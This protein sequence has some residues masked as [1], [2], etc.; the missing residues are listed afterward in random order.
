MRRSLPAIAGIFLLCISLASLGLS[1]WV[2][3]GGNWSKG[4]G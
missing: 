4:K 2:A 1:I 3:L